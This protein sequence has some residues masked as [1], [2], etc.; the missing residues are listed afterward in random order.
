MPQAIE[1]SLATPI[2]SPLFPAI[3]GPGS[4]IFLVVAIALTLVMGCPVCV[5]VR[6]STIQTTKDQC[7]VGAAKAEAIRHHGVNGDIVLTLAHD[8]HVGDGRVDGVDIGGFTNEAV[9]HH[10]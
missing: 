7:G 2:T 8:R 1:R 5:C 9:V 3:N 6:S 10:Q 4:A